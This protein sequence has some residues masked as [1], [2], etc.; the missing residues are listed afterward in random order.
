DWRRKVLTEVIVSWDQAVKAIRPH[1]S[2]I[3]NMGGASLMEFDLSLIRRHCP[4]LVVD[5]QGRHGIE[6]VWMS[7]RNGKRMRATFPERP[8]TQITSVGPEEAHRW[9]DAVTSGAEVQAWIAD[10][11]AHGLRPWCTK[12]N[13]VVPD[14]RWV[15]PVVE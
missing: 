7:G 11:M 10:G 3:P 4:F 14:R 1:A 2:F 8:V 12:F 5:D 15:E 6:P 9:K 13:G